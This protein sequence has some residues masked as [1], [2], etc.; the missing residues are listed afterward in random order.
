MKPEKMMDVIGQIDDALVEEFAQ[1]R[2]PRFRVPW[3]L[4]A[5]AACLCLVIASLVFLRSAGLLPVAPMPTDPTQ[6]TQPTTTQPTETT[7]LTQPTILP[8]P[9]DIPTDWIIEE[10]TSI[11][12]KII[13]ATPFKGAQGMDAMIAAF[14]EIYPNIEVELHTYYTAIDG[15]VSIN[16]VLLAGEVDVV[17]GVGVT[18]NYRRWVNGL[19]YDLTDM[20]EQEGIDLA[21]QWGTDAYTYDNKVYSFPCGGKSHYIAINMDAWNAAGLGELPTSWTWEEY[22]EACRKMTR[23]DDTGKTVVYGGSDHHDLDSIMYTYG[24]VNGGDLFYDWDGT[25]SYDSPVLLTALEQKLRAELEDGIWYPTQA[26]RND[27]V[28]SQQIFCQG[29]VA[30]TVAFNITN[31]LSNQETYPD[32]NWVT[33]FAPYP[34]MEAGQV[35]YMSGVMPDIHAGINAYIEEEKMPAAWAFLKWF[36][37]YGAKYL[38]VAGYQSTWRGTDNGELL[39]LIYGS[40]EEA[41]KWVD[42]ES[43][44]RVL[45][46]GDLPACMETTIK[47]Y[48]DVSYALTEPM[49]KAISGELSAQECLRQALEEAENAM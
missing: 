44:E 24:Q 37:T 46:R 18:G 5:T 2:P 14:N 41:T 3:S 15:S 27:S 26:Y 28:T 4:V 21:W 48:S 20:V 30:S 25:S 9:G 1:R 36:S 23:K 7:T 12:G 47:S 43:F 8:T 29:D 16:T 22:L 33:G 35:N 17:A 49:I 10:D 32:V 40:E 19:L 31:F 42:V 13:F 11:T 6:T 39:P 38:T 45:G 34:T